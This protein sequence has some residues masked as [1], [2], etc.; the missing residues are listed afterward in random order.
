MFKLFQLEEANKLLPAIDVFLKSIKEKKRELLLKL[1]AIK[2]YQTEKAVFGISREERQILAEQQQEVSSLERE[3]VSLIT[4]IE[5]LGCSVKDIEEGLVDFPAI[6]KRNPAYL[7]WKLG[8]PEIK[9][10]HGAEEGF[11]GRKSL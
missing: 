11:K 3:L 6:I 8:E 2:R 9:F 7:C 5:N 1:V 4:A 10:W